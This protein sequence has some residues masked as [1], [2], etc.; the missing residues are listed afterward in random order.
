MSI[1]DFLAGVMSF[2]LHSADNHLHHF[3]DSD[4]FQLDF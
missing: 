4:Y 3:I 2:S 1:D